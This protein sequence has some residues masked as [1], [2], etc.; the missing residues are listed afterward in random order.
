MEN[1]VFFFHATQ[2]YLLLCNHLLVC[3]QGLGILQLPLHRGES[4]HSLLTHPLHRQTTAVIAEKLTALISC[5]CSIK[6]GRIARIA[7]AQHTSVCS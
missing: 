2:C 5:D 6:Q 1:T 3:E 7:S 4:L